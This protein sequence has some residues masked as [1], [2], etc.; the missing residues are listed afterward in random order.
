MVLHSKITILSFN[1]FVVQVADWGG[2]HFLLAAYCIRHV[3][4]LSNIKHVNEEYV[5]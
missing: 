5:L 1:T 3:T 2:K 4:L